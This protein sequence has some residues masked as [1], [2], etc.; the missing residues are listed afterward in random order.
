MPPEEYGDVFKSVVGDRPIRRTKK[1]EHPADDT[2]VSSRSHR[3]N[4]FVTKAIQQGF[5]IGQSLA[6]GGLSF[7]SVIDRISAWIPIVSSAPVL[8]AGAHY[9]YFQ[10][11]IW[12]VLVMVAFGLVAGAVDNFVRSMVLKGRSKL[13]PLVSLVAIFGGVSMFGIIG[14]LMGPILAAVLISLLQIWP[15]VGGRFGLLSASTL[16]T[17]NYQDSDSKNEVKKAG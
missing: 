11:M 14:I 4:F 12:K 1:A 17:Q 9:L 10:G 5:V 13:H 3:H 8:V 7:R 2:G 15:A 6:D 16:V